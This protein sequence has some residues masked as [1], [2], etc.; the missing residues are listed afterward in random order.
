[1]VAV[2]GAAIDRHH[3]R[4]ARR[5]VTYMCAQACV[6]ERDAPTRR[7]QALTRRLQAFTCVYRRLQT[8]PLGVYKHH[9]AC[10]SSHSHRA[11]R[12]NLWIVVSQPKTLR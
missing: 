1:M 6:C 7:L 8:H 12:P 11:Q 5:I 10:R 9:R 2:V 3:D 4:F